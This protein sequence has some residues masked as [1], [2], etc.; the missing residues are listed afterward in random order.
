[1]VHISSASSATLPSTEPTALYFQMPR[2]TR[3]ISTSIFSWSPGSTGRLKRALSMPTK[4]TT[5]FSSGFTPIDRNDSRAA[6]CASASII[7]TPGMTG[8]CG[9]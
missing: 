2:E 1:M 4:Y 3:R 7:S 6:V 5:E 9:K 8:L